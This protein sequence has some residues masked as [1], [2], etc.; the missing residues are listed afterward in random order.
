MSFGDDPDAMG[1][2]W[3]PPP[4]GVLI[5]AIVRAFS[6]DDPDVVGRA[7]CVDGTP[8]AEVLGKDRAAEYFGGARVKP[9]TKQLVL[10]GIA[11]GL[12]GAGMVPVSHGFINRFSDGRTLDA[13]VPLAVSLTT[14]V[15]AWDEVLSGVRSMSASVVDR[16]LVCSPFLRLFGIE[17]ALRLMAYNV[18]AERSLLENPPELDWAEADGQNG[19]LLRLLDKLPGGRPGPVEI[20]RR[21]EEVSAHLVSHQA[22]SQWLSADPAKRS[23]PKDENL[24]AIAEWLG[25]TLGLDAGEVLGGLRRHTGLWRLCDAL[26]QI[27]GRP[28]VTQVVDRVVGYATV[29]WPLVEKFGLDQLVESMRETFGVGCLRSGSTGGIA[30]LTGRLENGELKPGPLMQYDADPLWQTDLLVVGETAKMFSVQHDDA[31]LYAWNRKWDKFVQRIQSCLQRAAGLARV[32]HLFPPELLQVGNVELLRMHWSYNRFWLPEWCVLLEAIAQQSPQADADLSEQVASNEEAFGQLDA[33]LDV[34]QEAVRLAPNDAYKAFRLG[35]LHGELAHI[36]AAEHWLNK[37]A[38][39]RRGWL[40]PKLEIARAYLHINRNRQA[41]DHLSQ[42]G[43]DIVRTNPFGL[44]L[45]RE[46][47]FRL[48]KW[49]LAKQYAEELIAVQ[50]DNAEAYLAHALA[51]RHLADETKDPKERKHLLQTGRE[52]AK[53]AREL[54]LLDAMGQY[55]GSGK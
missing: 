18:L 7:N 14:L 32:Q 40:L 6:L 10:E 23:P 41:F 47:S 33:A 51:C 35:A 29:A 48:K 43:E 54:G 9:E 25:P 22:V 24:R 8:V 31:W 36:G 42:L 27:V 16:G 2:R 30:T 26:A 53:Q 20:Q 34:W 38:D 55:E 1:E 44:I 52:S 19:L 4:S 13:W 12:V 3:L 15:K 37:A 45:L 50:D 49:N 39:L 28:T 21:L 46:S 5:G 17:F 11:K